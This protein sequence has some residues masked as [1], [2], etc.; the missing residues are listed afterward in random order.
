MVPADRISSGLSGA[1]I[2][3]PQPLMRWELPFAALV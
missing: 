3:E 1:G 2:F